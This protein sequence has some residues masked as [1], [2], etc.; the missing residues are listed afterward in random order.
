MQAQK[1]VRISLL[2]LLALIL[3]GL[4]VISQVPSAPGAHEDGGTFIGILLGVAAVLA[5]AVAGVFLLIEKKLIRPIGSLARSVQTQ[6][7]SDL[8]KDIDLAGAE[9]LGDLPAAIGQLSGSLLTA[10]R[11]MNKAV[12]EATLNLDEQ[13]RRLEAILHDL[14]EGVL[15]CNFNHQ[16]MLYNRRAL[17]LLH[18][19]GEMGLG[20]SL[21][22]IMNRQ[23][24]LHAIERL[25]N[26]LNEGRHLTHGLGV[27]FVG[28]TT[29]GRHT[30]EGRISLIID[31]DQN[32][33]GYLATFE[34][35][36]E[37]IAV[38][39]RRDRLLR[40]ATEGMRR[41][42][43]NVDV[44]VQTLTQHP[45]MNL[46][47]QQ[48]FIRMIASESEIL[49]SKLT[50]LADEY[51]EIITGSW[52]M[53]DVYSGNLLNCVV[54]RLRD[55]HTIEGVMTGIPQ[56]L[57]CDS[58]T[59]VE[60]INY[61]THRIHAFAEVA[62]VDFEAVSEGRK[63]YIDIRW[64]GPAIPASTVEAWMDHSLEHAFGGIT[65][66][67]VLD[68]HKSDMWFQQAEDGRSRIRIP[69]H[70]AM[71]TREHETKV[72]PSRPEFYD[73]GL[74]TVPKT[75]ADSPLRNLTYVVFDTETTGLRPSDGDQIV[76]IAGVRIVNGRI[77]TG[78]SFS[79][80]VH[81][82]RSIP[83][84]SIVFHGITDE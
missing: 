49:S 4:L 73:F 51:R 63:V 9:A 25:M 61:V 30:L 81:P 46:E 38:L 44:A 10:R 5:F 78:E 35:N 34:D 71:N 80:L 45:D 26:R 17:E 6:I 36:T 48:R 27:S 76:S 59:I 65:A 54:R 66:R 47:D 7:F 31:K 62:N 19:A 40:E 68:H 18:V 72:L 75:Q 50:H 11:E 12:A 16:I 79:K 70:A 20:R 28:T 42:V 82:G 53:A 22:S 83:K 13:K 21:F 55:E 64:D 37:T 14:H 39:A 77:L 23:P 2:A 58:Y 8:N 60:L 69:L 43:A 29:D 56:W 32:P 1:L 3:A 67:E 41:P 52:P 84:E 57:H 33:T 24:F 15:I 74:F